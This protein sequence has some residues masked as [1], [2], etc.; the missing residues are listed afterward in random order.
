MTTIATSA[1]AVRALTARLAEKILSIDASHLTPLAIAQA[2]M[3]F[4]DAIGVT[5]AGR[6]ENATRILLGT[7]GVATAP[8]RSLVFGTGIRKRRQ[9]TGVDAQDLFG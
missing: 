7:P 4:V 5:L 3:C 9:V 1:G 8:G 2:K 6:V